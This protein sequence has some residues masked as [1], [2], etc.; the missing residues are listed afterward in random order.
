ML[1][2]LLDYRPEKIDFVL[3]EAQKEMFKEILVVC[4]GAKTSKEAIKVF[5]EKFNC[6]FPEGEL[7]TRK[8]DEHEIQEIREEYCL[9]QENEVPK[10][11]EELETT[12]ERIKAM[13]KKAEEAYNS[14]LLEIADLAARVKKGTTDFALPAT[15]TIRVALNGNF[16]FFAWVDGQM[17]LV[18]VTEIPDW[19]RNS[20]WSQ[21]DWN[22]RAMKEVF[23]IEFPEVKKPAD[24]DDDEGDDDLPFGGDGDDD[25]PDD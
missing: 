12:L 13:K 8:Y 10:R 6:L 4:N 5:E 14:A 17:Q 24:A 9:K 19:D 7:A 21:E 20:L 15:E 16:C 23:G 22:R 18:K 3:T 1:A 2:N 25:N 11:K